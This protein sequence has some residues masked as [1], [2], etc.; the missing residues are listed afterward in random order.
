MTSTIIRHAALRAAL[1][2]YSAAVVSSSE[3]REVS[4]ATEDMLDSIL[5]EA[6]N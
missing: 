3:A 2:W 5:S 6:G 4:T 1:R